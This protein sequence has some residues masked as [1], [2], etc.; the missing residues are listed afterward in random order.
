MN[1]LNER[2]SDLVG[3]QDDP[4]LLS[5]IADLD[6][7]CDVFALP[8]EC[9][10]SIAHA[11]A[12]NTA[13]PRGRLPRSR[14]T[15]LR[16][17]WQTARWR[18][19]SVALATLL[20]AGGAGTYL[21][22]QSPTPVNAQTVLHRAEAVSPGPNEASHLIYRLSASGGYTGTGDVWVGIDANGGPSQLALTQTMFKDSSPVPEL[23]SRRVETDKT[24]Q[25][26]EPAKNLVTISSGRQADWGLV[27]IFVGTLV[28]QKLSRA[29]E[30]QQQNAFKME[31]ET[32]DG[33][34]VYA[35]A[36][37]IDQSG[38]ETFYFDTHSYVLRGADW[39]Q[40]G[41][42]WQA[43]LDHSDTMA[44]S[45]V[46]PHTFTLNAPATAR[47][48]TESS[49]Q[50]PSKR[51]GVDDSGVIAS[52]ATACKTTPGAVNA[53]LQAGDK[54]M[55]A[56]CQETSPGMTA[57]QLVTAL[58]APFKSA[59]DAQ[60]ASGAI[61]PAQEA[62]DLVNLQTKLTRMVTGPPGTK[63]GIKQP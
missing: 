22:G 19:A 31:Q 52:L 8:P 56:I 3:D 61:T 36:V 25:V 49:P 14:R 41:R 51:S 30:A 17:P 26:Y 38:P 48:V 44:L 1:P 6:A 35:V 13:T 39:V 55:L 40:D 10:A 2:Y 45:A 29:A 46:P 59:L 7:T 53:G 60:V 62:D 33:V 42:S 63:P 21:H 4:Q 27:G 16:V 9:D 24:V 37:T 5:C 11:L 54:S 20:V 43:R 23:S 12:V 58:M 15:W 34:P 47:V 18:L 28:A 32:L 57:D 50:E